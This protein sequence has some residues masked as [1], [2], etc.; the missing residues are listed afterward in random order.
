MKLNKLL[1][2]IVCAV[3]LLSS[4]PASSSP[5]PLSSAAARIVNTGIGR[6]KTLLCALRDRFGFLWVGTMTGLACFDGNGES[7]YAGTSGVL[8]NSEGI[9]VNSLFEYNDNIW[10]GGTTG[11]YIFDRTENRMERFP[12]KTQ[13]GVQVSSPVEKISMMPDGKIWIITHGQGLFIF[14]P[15]KARLIQNSREGA[16]YSDMVRGEADNVYCMTHDGYLIEFDEIGQATRRVRLPEFITDK[17]LITITFASGRVWVAS[18]RT[19]YAYTPGEENAQLVMADTGHGAANSLLSGT[20]GLLWLGTD[21]G[22]FCY[23]PTALNLRY[24]G[25]QE[26]TVGD[27]PTDV[28]VAQLVDDTDGGLIVVTHTGMSFVPY[29]SLAVRRVETPAGEIFDNTVNTICRASDGK[30]VWLGTDHGVAVYDIASGNVIRSSLPLGADIV[31]TALAEKNGCLWIGS[32]HQGLFRYDLAS[33]EVKHYEYNENKPYALIG[34]GINDLCLTSSG[35]LFVLTNWG[36]CRYDSQNDN[37]AVLTETG[38]AIPFLSM[39]EDGKGRLWTYTAT[40]NLYTRLRPGQRFETFTSPAIGSRGITL[41]YTDR[42]GRLWAVAGGNRLMRFD[43]E[44]NDFT[45]QASPVSQ[46]YPITFVQDGE[47]G[48]LWISTD[49]GVVRF[50]PT[51]KSTDCSFLTDADVNSVH[52]A[53][54]RLSDGSILFGSL[55]GLCELTPSLVSSNSSERLA[56]PISIS[57]PDSEDSDGRIHKLGLDKLLYTLKEIELPYS[58]N[59]FTI[60]FAS[61]SGSGAPRMHYQYMLEGADRTWMT[62]PGNEV[63]FSRL[64]PGKYNLL[65][66]ADS[67]A[68]EA[69]ISRLAIKIMPPWYLAWPAMTSYL[70]LFSALIW[71]GISTAR[72]RVKRQTTAKIREIEVQKERETYE[73]KMRFFI[74]LVHEIRTPLTLI[75]LPL[76]QLSD[77]VNS[78]RPTGKEE[79][80]MVKSMQRNLDYLLGIINQLLDFRKAEQDTEVKLL[81]RDTD[82]CT[83]V[84]D[85]CRRFKEPMASQGKNLTVELPPHPIVTALDLQKFDRVVMNLLGNAMKYCKDTVTVT[86]SAQYHHGEGPIKNGDNNSC[87]YLKIADDGQGIPEKERERIFDTYY[88]MAGDDVVTSLGT[89]LGLAYARLIARAHGGEITVENN[90]EGGSTFILRI[91]IASANAAYA[92]VGGAALPP[93]ENGKDMNTAATSREDGTSEGK[94]E[95]KENAGKNK[96]PLTILFVEDNAELRRAVTDTLKQRYKIITATDGTEALDILKETAAKATPGDAADASNGIDIIV[97]DFMMPGIDGAELCRRVKSDI[98]TSYIPFLML[99]AKTGREAKEESFG[100]GADAFVEKPF[101]LKQLTAQIDNIIHTRELFYE[102]M[103]TDAPVAAAVAEEA[104]YVN[105]MDMKFLEE[106]NESIMENLFDDEFSIDSMAEKMSMSRST[107]YRRMKAITGLTPVEYLK[108]FRLEQAARMLREGMRVTE[109]ASAVGFTSS[110]Y[111]AKCFKQR[112]GMLPKDYQV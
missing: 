83:D 108:N 77:S 107:F 97:S 4:L 111:F 10:F 38:N 52:G 16:F 69:G 29:D 49:E 86:L 62:L 76:E 32:R 17:N 73:S 34:N 106:L 46:E 9:N 20:D 47:N 50:N 19:I 28:R 74:N 91:P 3:A 45:Y 33:G 112:Y 44:K 59:T 89:G 13:Y 95:E 96:G 67:S 12:F 1:L 30:N 93:E 43:E 82:V 40:N 56:Y 22:I 21:E 31:V 102:R 15:A 92:N 23:S 2:S 63:T 85:I 90:P 57:F 81:L 54:E 94:S 64:R 79:K 70:A 39:K 18:N 42:S 41:L 26:M 48:D 87:L 36:M 99:T 51:T 37:F 66:K 61:A 60:H 105:K 80:G 6:D 100:A 104:P 75:S 103:R 101:S 25:L 53:S 14:D 65:V 35:E 98:A 55:K 8:P 7:V 71:F 110:S 58:D 5:E 84:A 68:S 27:S 109:V 88:Q 24:I 72:V 11:L 78:G